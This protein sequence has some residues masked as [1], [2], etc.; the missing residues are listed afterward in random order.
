MVREMLNEYTPDEVSRPGETLLEV[1]MELG[2]T[3]A[4][5]AERT[6]RPRKTINEIIN[7]IAAI[8]PETALHLERV[9]GIPASF[10]NNRESHY[11][12]YLARKAEQERLEKEIKWV[13]NFPLS[14]M[15][16][17]GWIDNPRDKVEKLKALLSYFGV[18]SPESWFQ[19]W[20]GRAAEY[21]KSKTLNSSDYALAAWLRR[22][23][24]V[25]QDV[26]C[27]PFEERRFKAILAGLR[28]L[29]RYEPSAY[30]LQIQKACA[31]CGVAVVFIP[32]LPGTRAWGATRWL[33]PSKA[34][35]QLSLRGKTD[36]QLW[37]T[38]LHECCHILKHGKREEFIE[39]DEGC[40]DKEDEA[41]RFAEELLIPRGSF[42]DFVEKGSFSGVAVLEFAYE[43]G[44]APGIVVGRLQK[45]GYIP[46]KNLNGLKRK[47]DIREN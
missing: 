19:M 5:L 3:Q 2:M 12:E 24:L 20:R 47:L 28:A 23:E 1:I 17:L 37:F 8:T 15:A 36:D 33:S 13:D 21:R 45:E 11:R 27:E 7:G 25:A 22:G 44:I 10:W 38:F 31:E 43:I 29:T 32:E 16:K 39:T 6:G 4:E 35:I 40:S 34:L 46:W 14:A 9:L 26:P 42:Q 41:N 18:A 30:L